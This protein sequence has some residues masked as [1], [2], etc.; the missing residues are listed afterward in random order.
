MASTI[1]LACHLAVRILK[2]STVPIM[3]EKRALKRK[4]CYLFDFETS[5]CFCSRLLFYC[6][7]F[8]THPSAH[9]LHSYHSCMTP[10]LPTS[11]SSP[12][13]PD[14]L[15]NPLPSSL[16][17]SFCTYLLR[18]IDSYISPP[19]LAFCLLLYTVTLTPWQVKTNSGC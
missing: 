12:P 19:I 4:H 17:A 5:V 13:A 15:M 6:C 7:I 18:Y 3:L 16:P 10:F 1:R 2:F 9:Y 11:I 14:L 8:H